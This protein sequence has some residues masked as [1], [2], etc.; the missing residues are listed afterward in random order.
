MGP[1]LGSSASRPAVLLGTRPDIA[2]RAVGLQHQP[3]LGLPQAQAAQGIVEHPIRELALAH[4]RQPYA[5]AVEISDLGLAVHARHGVEA[6]AELTRAGHHPP[7]LVAVRSRQ[8][9]EAGLTEACGFEHARSRGVAPDHW[10]TPPPQLLRDPA[11]VLD[12]RVGQ[13]EL[14]QRTGDRGPTRPCPTMIA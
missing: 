11:V 6:G 1:E 4:Q 7:R 2:Q 12:H 9:Q 14:G 5:L 8:D 13:L 10:H 3:C